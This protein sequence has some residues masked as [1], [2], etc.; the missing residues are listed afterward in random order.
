MEKSK[1]LDLSYCT[2]I[3]WNNCLR[4]ICISNHENLDELA[5]AKQDL[6]IGENKSFFKGKQNQAQDDSSSAMVVWRIMIKRLMFCNKSSLWKL[7]YTDGRNERI[8]EYVGKC[9]YHCLNSWKAY[10]NVQLNA[11]GFKNFKINRCYIFVDLDTG[12]HQM[13]LGI[14]QMS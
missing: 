14:S 13:P 10:K 7:G 2:I 8:K 9:L 12:A 4:E 11:T 5:Q 6:E 3:D 1:Q